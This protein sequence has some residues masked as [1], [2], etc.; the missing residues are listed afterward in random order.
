MSKTNNAKSGGGKEGAKRSIQPLG[1][2]VL[3]KPL[4]A[5]E[6]TTKS[7]AGII[8]PDT[9]D[10]EKPMQGKIIAVGEGRYSD[11][12]KLI[13]MRVKVGD[14]VVFSKYS[15]DE[16]KIEGEEYYI[17]SESSVLAVVN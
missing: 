6:T 9:V 16:I 8:I 3:L 12:G 4:S 5:E 14:R 17:L 2:R 10:K 13:P 11:E 15:P 7:A 1:D